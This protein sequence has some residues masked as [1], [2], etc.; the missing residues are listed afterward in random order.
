[1]SQNMLGVALCDV[2]GLLSDVLD[3]LSGADGQKWLRAI[4]KTLRGENPWDLSQVKFDWRAVYEQ[5]GLLVEYDD[6]AK[7]NDL[8]DAEDYW[9][10]PVIKGVTPNLVVKTMSEKL[11][12][13]FYL[14]TNDLNGSVSTN[15][16]DPAN[17]SYLVRFAKNV[18]ADEELQNQSADQL[19][20]AGV[21]GNT[22]LERFLL[23]MAYFMSTGDHLDVKNVTLCS[24]SR[25][26]GGGVPDVRWNPERRKL[27]VDWADRDDRGAGLR[28][29]EV[30]SLT[31]E[32]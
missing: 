28:S 22:L 25:Y 2:R 20:E 21:K 26:S 11:G 18:E 3:R 27:C 24:G 29:R 15:D 31:L 30:V 14:Y 9:T 5:L 4:K 10:V 7:A 8:A 1:M 19:A 32:T 23:G 17:G 12:V 13:Q 6:F 16:R